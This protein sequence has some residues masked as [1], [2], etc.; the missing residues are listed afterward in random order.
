MP[1]SAA[2]GLPRRVAAIAIAIVVGGVG[3]AA[4]SYLA[5][6][7]ADASESVLLERDSA[8]APPRDELRRTMGRAYSVAGATELRRD[9]GADD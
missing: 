9:G 6:E 3:A 5:T 1:R 2:G 7:E 8:T 4:W